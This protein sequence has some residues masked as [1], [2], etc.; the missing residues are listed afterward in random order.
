MITLFSYIIY[1][2]ENYSLEEAIKMSIDK[3]RQ[4]NVLKEF[5]E[6]YSTEVENMIM[7]DKKAA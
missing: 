2:D 1:L 5:L 6:T 7:T 4:E 3:C